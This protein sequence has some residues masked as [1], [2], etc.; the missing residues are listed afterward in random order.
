MSAVATVR[1]TD[2]QCKR[3]MANWQLR[4]PDDAQSSCEA[5]KPLWIILLMLD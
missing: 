5:L 3:L 4:H 2:L 1:G